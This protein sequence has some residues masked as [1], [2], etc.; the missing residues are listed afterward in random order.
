MKSTRS[1]ARL[2]PHR[3]IGQGA[4]SVRRAAFAIAAMGMLS[5]CEQN[6]FV[7]PPPP[8]VDVAVPLQRPFT[9]YLEATGNTAA[10]KNVD[11]PVDVDDR[12]AGHESVLPRRI[13]Q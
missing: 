13:D 1:P 8:K 5:A 3:T 6:T 7:P 10:I 11:A 4:A 12:T 9:R 2:S